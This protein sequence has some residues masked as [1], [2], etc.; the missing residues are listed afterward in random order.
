MPFGRKYIADTLYARGD[1][2][3]ALDGSEYAIVFLDLG[4]RWLSCVPTCERSAADARE[5]MRDFAGPD[6]KTESFYSDGAK[7]LIK[8]A[9]KLDWCHTTSIPYTSSNNGRV[10]RAI[11]HVE[12]GTRTVLCQA[13]LSHKW[14]PFASK[15]FCFASNITGRAGEDSPYELRHKAGPFVGFRVPMGSAIHFRPNKALAKKLP[16]LGPNGIPGIFVGWHVPP[17]GLWKGEYLVA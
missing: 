4:T 3:R 11:R 8:A 10:E 15:F 12:E 2:S 16:K 1:K 6:S 5:A 9:R 13:G 14:W 17:G 7:E